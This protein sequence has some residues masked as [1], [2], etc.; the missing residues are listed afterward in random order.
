MYGRTGG[1]ED[2]GT[3]RRK[4]KRDGKKEGKGKRDAL[5]YFWIIHA[6]KSEGLSFS[7]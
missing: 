7:A 4:S 6:L 2:G 3:E 1:Q 5:W